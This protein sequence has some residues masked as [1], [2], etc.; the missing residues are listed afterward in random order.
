VFEAALAAAAPQHLPGVLHSLEPALDEYG[1]LAVF[2]FVLLEDFGVPVPG[3][4]ILI[5]GAVYAGTGRL[6]V[7]LVGLIGLIAAV[8]GDNIGFLIGHR[9]GRPLIERYGRYLLIT[10]ERLERAT[11]FFERHGGKVVAV[12]RF[13]EG[14]RQ[15]NG[16]IAGITG[17]HWARFLLFNAIGAA[18]WVAVWTSIGYVSGSN[19]TS[20]YDTA[21][22]YSTYLAIAF[23]ALVVL[24]FARLLLRHTARARR[25]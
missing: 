5:L 9:G 20:I 24:Y 23:G 25:G 8:L 4:T 1:Y 6:N 12:A 17:M 7:V 14:L 22:S 21:T 2:A 19:I 13:I 16:I 15:A 11:G 3:E 18:L 10:P